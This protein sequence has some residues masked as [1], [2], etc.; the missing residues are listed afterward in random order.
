MKHLSITLMALLCHIS[1]Q[2]AEM[3]GK[4]K[5]QIDVKNIFG[6]NSAAIDLYFVAKT[7][8]SES[9]GEPL[10]GQKAVV[11]VIRNRSRKYGISIS[12]SCFKGFEGAR[13]KSFEKSPPKELI[14]MCKEVLEGEQLHGYTYF[15]NF[16]KVGDTK[17]KRY[18]LGRKG[19]TVGN[20]FF[21]NDQAEKINV[22]F[23]QRTCGEST[24]NILTK[25]DVFDN[26]IIKFEGVL[27]DTF[28]I[29][30]AQKIHSYLFETGKGTV[31]FNKNNDHGF[32]SVYVEGGCKYF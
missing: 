26:K 13:Q 10:E 2:T 27:E 19:K 12:E 18:S 28:Y 15:I 32:T 20:H 25:F 21:Y 11:Q 24:V 23:Y 14:A 6:T 8:Y 3:P 22:E 30:N 7:V 31:F 4:D 9:R 17:W 5:W 16:A 1:T 29:Q